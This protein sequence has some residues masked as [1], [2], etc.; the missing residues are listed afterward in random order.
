MQGCKGGPGP[1]RTW[2]DVLLL[3]WQLARPA[4]TAA[5]PAL[6]ALLDRLKLAEETE[7]GP[8]LLKWLLGDELGVKDFEMAVERVQGAEGRLG[9]R[10]DT[11]TTFCK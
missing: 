4:L 3:L 10:V 5:L 1:T 11:G 9:T 6:E 2:W 7:H 8:T